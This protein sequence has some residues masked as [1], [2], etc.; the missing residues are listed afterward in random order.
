MK[1]K[2]RK[3]LAGLILVT[4]IL[5][6][7]TLVI[8]IFFSGSKDTK[9]KVLDAV[10]NYDYVLEERDTALFKETYNH[11]KANLKSKDIDYTAYAADLA[12]LFIIDLFT[13]DNKLSKYDI[14]GLDYVYPDSQDNYKLNVENTLYKNVEVKDNKRNQDLP[15]VTSITIDNTE[16]MEYTIGEKTYPAYKETISWEY[17]EDFGYDNK[18]AVTLIKDQ[19]K[20][21][22]VEYQTIEE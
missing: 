16:E 21:Y 17:K 8:R 10:K 12:Q 7:A 3:I 1:R 18:A 14:G 13:I 6:A 9:V 15:A 4:I 5:V 11:L 19:N 20:V 22:V 2:Y